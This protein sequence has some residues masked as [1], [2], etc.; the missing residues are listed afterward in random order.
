MG[1]LLRVGSGNGKEGLFCWIERPAGDSF[2]GAF[3]DKHEAK[4]IACLQLEGFAAQVIALVPVALAQVASKSGTLAIVGNENIAIFGVAQ[5]VV[6]GGLDELLG[7]VW[8]GEV[9]GFE[10]VQSEEGELAAIGAAIEKEV[11]ADG[12][13]LANGK[14]ASFNRGICIWGFNRAIE[15]G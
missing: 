4:P 2:Y 5:G 10:S 6:G 13:A 12:A 9:E 3:G 7:V 15:E 14:D 1:R 8:I 11:D